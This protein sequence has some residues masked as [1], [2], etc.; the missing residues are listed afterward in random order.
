MGKIKIIYTMKPSADSLECWKR[1]IAGGMDI[2]CCPF[3]EGSSE[4]NIRWIRKMRALCRQSKRPVSILVDTKGQKMGCETADMMRESD[5]LISSAIHSK[6]DVC[7]MRRFLEQNG[8]GRTQIIV[9]LSGL[10]YD[11]NMKSLLEA[12][13]G[14]MIT[15]HQLIDFQ[16][17]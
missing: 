2:V 6:E 3:S 11:E 5:Y 12:A 14:I 7:D 13:D 16:T 4:D 8:C 1:L 15:E 10:T 9:R 17:A